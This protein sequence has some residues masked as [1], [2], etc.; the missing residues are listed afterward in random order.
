MTGVRLVVR[1]AGVGIHRHDRR[2]VGH[3]ILAGE[4][5]HEPLLDLVLGGAAIADAACRSP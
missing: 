3:Q 1:I 2:I 4:R 5:F